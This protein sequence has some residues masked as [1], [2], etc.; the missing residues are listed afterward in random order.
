MVTAIEGPRRPLTAAAD[1]RIAAVEV[2]NL[3]FDYPLGQELR[4]AQEV[5]NARLTSLVF[6]TASNGAVGVGSVNSHPL[7]TEE[8]VERHLGPMI[9]GEPVRDIPA[10][11]DRMYAQTRWYGRKG[12]ALSAIGGIDTAL[13]DCSASWR[14]AR[15]VS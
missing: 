5:C 12:V 3:R 6:V 2:K 10:L 8:I 14:T 1:A 9:I 7:L 11:W 13:W 15:C 4:S